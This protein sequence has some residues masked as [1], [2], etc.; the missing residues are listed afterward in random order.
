MSKRPVVLA[1]HLLGDV[2]GSQDPS[3]L[4]VRPERFRH[5]V[6]SLLSRGYEFVTVS[7]F[8]RRMRASGPPNG[9]CALSFDDGSEDNAQLLPGL[10][11]ELGVPATLFVCPGLLGKPHPWL[12]PG[13]GVR[14][15]SE[16]ELRAVAGH[17]LIEIGSHTNDHA[18]LSRATAAEAY[19]ELASSKS[20]LEDLLGDPVPSFAYPFCRYSP[21]CPE[22][23]AR[24]GYVC[25]V[26]CEGRGGWHPYELRREGIASWDGRFTFAL[27]SRGFA[28]PLWRSTPGRMTL[29]ARRALAGWKPPAIHC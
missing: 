11:E 22:A 21:A 25:A 13:A 20:G 15:M 29:R 26:T 24:A 18:D 10:L 8:A 9:V 27:K 5:Q 4:T 28:H 12:A 2:P 1:Y 17:R 3:S 6:K 16:S 19:R 14:L 23:A 7:E